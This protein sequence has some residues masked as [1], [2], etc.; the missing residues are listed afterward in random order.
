MQ[1]TI[2]PIHTKLAAALKRAEPFPI[3]AMALDQ[4]VNPQAVFV[5]F[6]QPLYHSYI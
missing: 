3:Y 4:C 6:P 5:L 2:P 1:C